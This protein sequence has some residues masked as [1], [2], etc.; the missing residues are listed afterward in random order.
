MLEKLHEHITG[1]L[2]QGART[3]TIFV[4]TGIVFNLII[5]AVNSSI[6]S[7]EPNARDILMTIFSILILIFNTIA[8][9]GLLLGRNTRN[10]LLRGLMQMYTDNEVEKYYDPALLANYNRRYALFTGV[11]ICLGITAF[12]VPLVI[13][14]V[15]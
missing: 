13:R 10:R 4:I 8:I 14:F 6:A 7:E 15:N 2:N 11:I 5:L 9:S 1:E 12:V 3:D